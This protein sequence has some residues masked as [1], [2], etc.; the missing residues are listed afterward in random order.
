MVTHDGED[1]VFA[2][3]CEASRKDSPTRRDGYVQTQIV[4]PEEIGINLAIRAE[5]CIKSAIAVVSS[6][7]KIFPRLARGITCSDDLAIGLERQAKHAVRVVE[8]IGGDST[9]RS[10]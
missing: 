3:R 1:L 10:E 4:A 6:H 8:E 5:R 9:L 7:R 2:R